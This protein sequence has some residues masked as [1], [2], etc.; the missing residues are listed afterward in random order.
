[1]TT[2]DIPRRRARPS[3]AVAVVLGV[4]GGVWAGVTGTLVVQFSQ[5]TY[6][7][8]PA[9]DGGEA[10]RHIHWHLPVL[11]VLVISVGALVL[12]V[13]GIV[14]GLRARTRVATWWARGLP[15]VALLLA[16]A[17]PFL[18]LAVRGAGPMF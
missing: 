2:Q 7:L 17:A 8:P 14:R 16:T 10:T 5:I 6:Y 4:L 12:A 13:L 3:R 1:M 9:A 18:A 11:W 15:V